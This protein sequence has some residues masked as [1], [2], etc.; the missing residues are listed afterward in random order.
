M[1]GAAWRALDDVTWLVETLIERHP[2]G[3]DV[4]LGEADPPD[5]EDIHAMASAGA[6]PSPFTGRP[7]GPPRPTRA[8]RVVMDE[9]RFLA[10]V[11]AARG[12]GNIVRVSREHRDADPRL[13]AVAMDH[14]RFVGT[15]TTRHGSRLGYVCARYA[16]APN[17]VMKYRREFPHVLARALLMPPADCDDFYLLPGD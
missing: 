15:S 5:A 14:E 7:V 12:W 2:Q 13:W 8:E 9:E 6:T 4:L 1:G 3:F 16:L 10:A 11:E 17:T